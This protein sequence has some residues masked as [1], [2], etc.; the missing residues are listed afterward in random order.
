MR[1]I[2]VD[3]EVFLVPEEEGDSWY[4]QRCPSCQKRNFMHLSMKYDAQYFVCGFCASNVLMSNEEDF[5][6]EL[7]DSGSVM[8]EDGVI[9]YNIEGDEI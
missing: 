1:K 3:G 7:E 5:L 6:E 9:H 2:E 8:P 4:S